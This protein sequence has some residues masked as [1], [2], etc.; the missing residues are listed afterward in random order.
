[1]LSMLHSRSIRLASLLVLSAAI[2]SSCQKDLDTTSMEMDQIR[3]RGAN[4]GTISSLAAVG[5]QIF[6]DN[7]LSNP[8]GSQA[9]ASCHMPS[10]GFSGLGDGGIFVQGI[11]MGAVQN[12]F[13][14]RKPPSAA[15]ASF[16][17]I[18][19]LA[20]PPP[21]PAD[22]LPPAPEFHGGLFWDG[23][24]TGLR[25]GNAAA[26]QAL[27]PFL[28]G[29]EHNLPGKDAVLSIIKNGP[30][31][32]Q[33]LAA[34]NNEPIDLSTQA[35][36]DANYDKVGRAIA[37]YEAT[38]EVN[39]FTSKF[40]AFQKGQI[41]LS[42]AEARGWALFNQG[43]ISAECYDCHDPA[44][45]DGGIT[46]PLFTDFGY[47][48]IGLPKNTATPNK[49][50]LLQPDLG[51]GGELETVLPNGQFKYPQ[52]W[53][54]LAVAQYGKFKTPTLRNLT[55]SGNRRYMHNG[56]F[57]SLEAVVHFYNTRDVPGAGWTFDGVFK[58]WAQLGK[59]VNLNVEIHGAGNLG[60][61]AAQEADLV[62]FLKTLDDGYRATV[63]TLNTTL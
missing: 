27:G 26:E 14:G 58:T 57:N 21:D 60:L 55:L 28:A 16:A 19:T 50:N 37:A 5:R 22:P 15:Y 4:G 51:L 36:I 35:A 52:A 40:D 41:R 29:A 2:L 1:M 47:H 18:M 7:R 11:G 3:V 33:W 46:P 63:G 34:F 10:A 42:A 61:T 24:A 56:I 23:R 43:P 13:G 20:I 6:F 53:R 32:N 44:S 25:L 59:E 48:N 9:C 8:S 17:P 45:P 12:A 54:D 39:K 38:S 31:Y 30:Y 49:S 62:A